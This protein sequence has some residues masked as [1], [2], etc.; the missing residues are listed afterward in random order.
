MLPLPVRE[1]RKDRIMDPAS[2]RML[3]DSHYKALKILAELQLTCTTPDLVGQLNSLEEALTDINTVIADVSILQPSISHLL[4]ENYPNQ[5]YFENA[6]AE[7]GKILTALPIFS[8]TELEVIKAH[9]DFRLRQFR[10]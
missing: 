2:L 10:N 5:S 9:V 4:R 3:S 6:V 8:F 7:V 1:P